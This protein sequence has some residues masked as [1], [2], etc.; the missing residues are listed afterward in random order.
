MA[1]RP[2][3]DDEHEAYRESFRSFLERVVVGEYAGWQQ[4]GS[5]PREV[6]A[7]AGE[8]GFAAM[9]VPE[10]HGGVGIDDFRFNLVLAEET[11]RAGVAGFGLML[12][13]HNDVCVPALVAGGHPQLETLA[14]GE[15][16]AAWAG[17]GDIATRDGKLVGE[18]KGVV[19]GGVADLV[20]VAL[21]DGVAVVDAR[22]LRRERAEPLVGMRACDRADL[23]FD[24]VPVG[25]L[26]PPHAANEPLSIAALAL[27]GARAALSWTLDYVRERRAF[28]I[29]IAEFQNTR[30]ALADVAAEL[31]V[32]QAYLDAC[33]LERNAGELAPGRAAAAK[34]RATELHG[35]AVDWGVQLHGGYGYMLEYPIAHAF[36]DARYLRLHGGSSEAMREV[37]ARSIG[38]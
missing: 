28:G 12:A 11:M 19:N 21:D 2:L 3:F 23:T 9:Q 31:E 18:A 25:E 4:T 7:V 34:L 15:V 37:I 13:T 27:G 33:V 20:L 5:I 16:L 24:G 36:A 32:T 10:A 38:V 6:F 26:L 29:P 1:S 30:Y 8:H 17:P 22:R 35:R 14:S